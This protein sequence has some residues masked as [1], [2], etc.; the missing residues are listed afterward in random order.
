M[1][2]SGKSTIGE[3]TANR[4]AL[5]YTDCDRS[6]ERRAGC[7]IAAIFER[8]GEHGFREVEA[9]VLGIAVAES[10]S[11]I[12]TGG[13]VVLR[14]ANRELLRTHTCCVYL[15]ASHELLWRRLRRDRR[16]PLLQVADPEQRL[17][18]MSAERGPLYEQTAHIVI[19]TDGVAI[20]HLVDEVVR[21]VSTVSAR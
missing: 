15:R 20:D 10:A 12:A 3:A 16:R 6:I 9:E 11:V 14:D 19:D 7:S 18:Q 1:P 4:L 21:R 5:L 8:S 2:G 17:R 13:G